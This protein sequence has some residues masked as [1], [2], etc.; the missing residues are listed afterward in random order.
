MMRRALGAIARR[1][2]RVATNVGDAVG[3]EAPGSYKDRSRRASG[4]A[5]FIYDVLRHPVDGRAADSFASVPAINQRLF[6]HSSICTARDFRHPEFER[7]REEIGEAPRV[8][9][10]IWEHVFIAAHLEAAGMLTEGRKGLGFG[11]GQ[12]PLPAV[13]AARGASVVG[14]DMAPDDAQAAGWVSTAQHASSLAHLNQKGLCPQDIFDARVSFATCDM[15]KI[16]A[17]LRDFDFTWSS[18]SLEHLGSIKAGLEF[19][20]A[21]VKTLKAGGIAIHTTEYNVSSN[22]VTI[23]NNP[24]LV[25]FRRRDIDRLVS[26]LRSE[27]HSVAD[28]RYDLLTEPVDLFVDIPPY[29]SDT[30]IR[31]VL[32]NFVSTSIGIVIQR[33]K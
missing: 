7:W 1:T 17:S 32:S 27:G 24:S 5:T 20:K 3:L 4:Q 23:D 31:L 26:E 15:T 8:H 11:V 33:G 2:K 6:F 25:L 28:I 22:D 9:R 13:F 18:C 14:T 30:H 10:K 19:I 29:T 21:S 12:E 16:P